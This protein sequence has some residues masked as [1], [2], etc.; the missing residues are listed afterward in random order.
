VNDEDKKLI[1]AFLRSLT[2]KIPSDYIRAPVLPPSPSD[3][4]K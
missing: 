4:A 2:G 1:A 3:A